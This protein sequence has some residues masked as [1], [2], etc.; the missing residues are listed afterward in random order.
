[1]I[2][3]QPLENATEKTADPELHSN[4]VYFNGIGHEL[5]LADA[6]WMT[7]SDGLQPLRSAPLESLTGHNRP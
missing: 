4:V 3:E 1:V 5:S 7:A 6:D 2:A